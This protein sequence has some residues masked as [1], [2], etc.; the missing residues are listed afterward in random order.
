M[1]CLRSLSA[2]TLIVAGHHLGAQAAP[3]GG[4]QHVPGM[5][6][7]PGMQHPDATVQPT[8]GGQAAFAAIT[9]IVKLLEADSTTDW[10]KVDIEA[11]RQHLVDMDAV[12]M[13]A[14]VRATR[15]T[16]G[17]IMDVTGEPMVAASIRRML[18]SHAPM[19][20][21]MGGWRATATTIPG[22]TRL[23]V[24]ASNAADAGTI[25]RIRGLGFIGLMTQGAHHPEHHLL[26]AKGAG[27][28]AHGMP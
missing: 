5:Q 15:T 8:Q 13:R 3:P 23:T 27:A 19:L 10:S 1:H 12:T 2:L 16:G 17:L 20:E 7:T 4:M 9:E 14:R 6:H 25:A 22:G 11:L 28:H 18:G 26:I 21:A 24:V